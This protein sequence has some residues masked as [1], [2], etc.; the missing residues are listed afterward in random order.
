MAMTRTRLSA[1]R[2]AWTDCKSRGFDVT[3]WQADEMGRWRAA[4]SGRSHD[5][6]DQRKD[7]ERDEISS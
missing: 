7:F 6:E 2:A 1:A 5:P 4:I 3:Y